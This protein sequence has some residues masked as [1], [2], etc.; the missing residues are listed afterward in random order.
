MQV[1]PWPVVW[2]ILRCW[3][4]SFCDKGASFHT[5]NL[6][7]KQG[8]YCSHVISVPLVRHLAFR[9]LSACRF[10]LFQ[11]S[12]FQYFNSNT[13]SQHCTQAVAVV[14]HLL[15]GRT[16]DS[17]VLDD[18]AE[19]LAAEPEEDIVLLSQ[20]K[21]TG[22]SHTLGPL[23]TPSWL[24]AAAALASSRHPCTLERVLIRCTREE[25]VPA[26][27]EAFA[28]DNNKASKWGLLRVDV[29]ESAYHIPCPRLQ[30][31][32]ARGRAQ[33]RHQSAQRP[34]RLRHVRHGG[35]RLPG[36]RIRRLRLRVAR[37]RG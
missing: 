15:R 33:G 35:R 8:A 31:L 22:G 29:C 11:P 13:G 17:G 36:A 3:R 18:L 27:C 37:A 32:R 7:Y 26:P 23:R 25:Y 16:D 24:G 4:T 30:A 14:K 34:Q 20:G 2:S 6:D 28:P 19:L 9:F 12:H 5:R 21:C 10:P 1:L